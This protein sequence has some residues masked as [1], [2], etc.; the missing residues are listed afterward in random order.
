MAIVRCS[1]LQFLFANEQKQLARVL[2]ESS[3][4]ICAK[5]GGVFANFTATH[6]THLLSFF[7]AWGGFFKKSP[8]FLLELTNKLIILPLNNL[9]ALKGH[10]KVHITFARGNNYLS[11]CDFAQK[12]FSSAR[13]EL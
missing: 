8:T 1:K 10:G 9:N 11:V 7:G 2:P 4:V 13:V 12:I 5:F 3:A 6:L